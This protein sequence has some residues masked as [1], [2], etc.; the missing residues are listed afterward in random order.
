MGQCYTKRRNIVQQTHIQQTEETITDERISNNNA[1][2]NQIIEDLTDDSSEDTDSDDND[3]LPECSICLSKIKN[4][5]KFTIINCKHSFHIKCISRWKRTSN[6]CPMC[7][8]PIVSTL[9]PMTKRAIENFINQ[10]TQEILN[11]YL[12]G[13]TSAIEETINV[14]ERERRI[15]SFNEFNRNRYNRVIMN[16]IRDHNNIDTNLRRNHDQEELRNI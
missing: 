6:E 4:D 9:R 3:M 1:I 13:T 11:E 5:K 16:R 10:R 7:R 8:G 15:Q 2:I 12:E 14:L